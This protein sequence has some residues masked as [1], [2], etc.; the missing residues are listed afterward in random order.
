MATSII[1]T[2]TR[3]AKKQ[4]FKNA[5]ETL[6]TVT[7]EI[8]REQYNKITDEGTIKFFRR[9]GG[10]ESVTKNY[11]SLGYIP[12]KIISTSPDKNE[13]VIREFE[14]KTVNVETSSLPFE[15]LS[16][17]GKIRRL[18]SKNLYNDALRNDMRSYE[19]GQITFDSLHEKFNQVNNT[20][21]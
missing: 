20:S 12:V 11:T 8:T 17:Y 6:E 10:Y 2:E 1:L 14:F 7:K 15:Q 4:G 3:Q 19:S 21:L 5:Y 16:L 18:Q 9:L 13:K